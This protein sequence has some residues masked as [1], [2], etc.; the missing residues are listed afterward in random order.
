MIENENYPYVSKPNNSNDLSEL[1]IALSSIKKSIDG[2]E[3]PEHEKEVE[4][5]NFDVLRL[6]IKKEM[7]VLAEKLEK[8]VGS[9]KV[10]AST[11][12]LKD[13]KKAIDGLKEEFSK[14]DFKP[15]INIPEI[16]LPDINVP[17]PIVNVEAPIVNSPDV[18][19]DVASILQ[20]LVPLK[21]ISDRA[22]KPISVRMSD[23][24][25]FIKAIKELK[26]STDQLGVVYAGSSGVSQDEVRTVMNERSGITLPKFDYLSRVLT[27]A[28]KETYTYKTGGASGSTVATVV[29]DYEDATLVTIT[30]VT[31]T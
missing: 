27:S 22:D 11:P 5:S 7:T 13:L 3:F 4:I 24:Q 8:I 10:E 16:K 19:I 9:I 17:Q 31:K 26:E 20:A 29:V 2:L 6:H 15:D 30:A 14:I 25:R 28:T 12:E 23:G 1:F 21:H 18:V